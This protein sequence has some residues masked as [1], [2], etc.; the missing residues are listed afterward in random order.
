MCSLGHQ[1]HAGLQRSI[2][3]LLDEALDDFEAAF[4][5]LKKLPSEAVDFSILKQLAKAR[6]AVGQAREKIKD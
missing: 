5:E 3:K 4:D 1:W 6:D 2:A